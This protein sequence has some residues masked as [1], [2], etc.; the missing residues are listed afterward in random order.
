MAELEIGDKVMKIGGRYGGPGVVVGKTVPLHDSDYVLYSVAME[1]KDG[2][3]QF[4]HV[5]PAAVL[6]KID[7]PEKSDSPRDAYFIWDTVRRAW[8]RSHRRGY[9]EAIQEA[10]TYSRKEALRIVQDS[11]VGTS[12]PP[13]DL[14]VRVLDASAFMV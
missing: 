11:M 12:G 7:E 10:G 13:G 8:W 9:T 4:V 6:R 2:F 3:G 1:V 14:M 5:F